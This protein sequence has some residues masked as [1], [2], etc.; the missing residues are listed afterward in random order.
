MVQASDEVV[1]A[2]DDGLF[3]G[4]Y[5][6]RKPRNSHDFDLMRETGVPSVGYGETWAKVILM[7]EHS[8]VYGYPAVALPVRQLRMRAWAR[9]VPC[10]STRTG[11]G[12]QAR[13][14]HSDLRESQENAA[15]SSLRDHE[16]TIPASQARL[17]LGG[18]LRALDYCG[19][20][21]LA[22]PRFGGVERAVR[23][24]RDFAGRPDL[25]FDITTDCSFPAGR[26]MGSSAASAGAVI[27]AILSACGVKASRRQ[28]LE[29]TQKAEVITHGRPSG[30]DTVATSSHQAVT[31]ESGSFNEFPVSMDAYLVIAD[32]GIVGSTREAVGL[33]GK[34]NEHDGSRV[35]RI[36]DELGT[37]ARCSQRDLV[38]GDVT[39]LGTRM[40]RA[41]AL[42]AQLK[43]SHPVVDRLA[44]VACGA[45]AEGAKMTG[46]GL[47]GCLVALTKNKSVA[48]HVRDS[49]LR[50]GAAGAWI[51]S[52]ND[53]AGA[54]V[55][56]SAL[57]GGHSSRLP[58]GD[59]ADSPR[60]PVPMQ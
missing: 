28:L 57:P 43:V 41:H 27:R 40:N 60:N 4:L 42:L 39:R 18:R 46:G 16:C 12:V 30:L 2:D 54:Q 58:L 9:P 5:D 20:L 36:M 14:A 38:I 48:S 23:V 33:V 47:G 17:A 37:L 19:P 6:V 44:G 11:D 21:R 32:S 51:H 25:D 35:K 31:F 56:G 10:V 45:G 59:G 7:G 53:D 1:P 26:G 15:V 29:L 8:V 55:C 3:G 34:Q 22:G 13:A 49:L 52:L 50:E 24:A